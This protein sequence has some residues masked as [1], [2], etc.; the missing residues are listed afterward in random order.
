MTEVERVRLGNGLLLG[1]RVSV[2]RRINPVLSKAE[3][4]QR[5]LL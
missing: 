4:Y 5:P 2:K 3:W 1:R